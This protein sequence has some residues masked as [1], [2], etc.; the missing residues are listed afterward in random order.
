MEILLIYLCAILLLA[1]KDAYSRKGYKDFTISGGKESTFSVFSTLMAT[2]LGASLTIG[3]AERIEDIGSGGIIWIWA[4]A[5]GLLLQGLFLSKA[6]KTSSAVTLPELAGMTVGKGAQRLVALIIAIS[7]PAIIAAQ[8][9]AI[10][11]LATS[12]LAISN[13]S[14]ISAIVAVVIILYALIGGQRTSVRIDKLQF[15]ILLSAFIGIGLWILCSKGQSILPSLQND[16][17]TA[18]SVQ[19]YIAVVLTVGGAFFLGPDIASRS[20]LAKNGKVAARAV[21]WSSLALF[22]F[23]IMI[24]SLA[25]WAKA[26]LPGEGNPLFRIAIAAPKPIS[27]LF[28][29]GLLATLVS[30]VDTCLINAASIV[31]NDIIG[32]K[33]VSLLRIVILAIGLLSLLL[34]INFSAIIHLLLMAYSVYTPGIIFPLT[35]AIFAK[36]KVEKCLW[37]LSVIIGG[38]FGLTNAILSLDPL[39]PV[40]GMV[41]S[42]LLALSSLKLKEVRVTHS[43]FMEHK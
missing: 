13:S 41:L 30:S 14:A 23:G 32:I 19:E 35:I 37:T 21:L 38:A 18:L 7:W 20:F 29:I 11:A 33:R 26:N 5:L 17:K 15:A 40:V 16:A 27:L 3:S 6:L 25:L 39:L 1:L 28:S 24:M 10:G 36:G 4:G 34:A 9:V 43:I 22:L 8:F 2:M 31:T 12:T 42:L